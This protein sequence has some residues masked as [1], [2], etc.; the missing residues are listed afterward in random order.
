[1]DAR[2]LQLRDQLLNNRKILAASLALSLLLTIGTMLVGYRLVKRSMDDSRVTTRSVNTPTKL[3][4]LLQD[5]KPGD[6]LN[7][8]VYFNDVKLESGN[9]DNVYYAV[10]AEG[11]R[12]LVVALGS[13][14]ALS[15]DAPVDIEGTVRSLP[16]DSQMR[17][18]WKL[19]KKEVKAIRQQGIFIEADSIQAKKGAS[20]RLA[21]K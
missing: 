9:A 6:V 21:K 2:V 19:D 13:K 17:S 5:Q 11:E 3:G 8:I 10:G 18:K 15:E 1:M 7:H 16:P 14:T 12:L 20:Q 4:L